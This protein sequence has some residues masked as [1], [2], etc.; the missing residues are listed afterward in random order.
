MM[1]SQTEIQQC[2]AAFTLGPVNNVR[3]A[4]KP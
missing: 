2:P 1:K 3:F 4:R